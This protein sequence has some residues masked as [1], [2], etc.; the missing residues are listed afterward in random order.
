MAHRDNLKVTG[1]EHPAD[2]NNAGPGDFDRKAYVY[3]ETFANGTA[4]K[5]IASYVPC[6]H[7]MASVASRQYMD[8]A[9]RRALPGAT[10][11][12]TDRTADIYG[13]F[14]L[15]SRVRHYGTGDQQ[16]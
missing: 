1:T 8:A 15:G 12:G 13:A 4:V 5:V 2:M 7:G 10:F 14:C 6:G 3:V 16:S 9:A 11:S